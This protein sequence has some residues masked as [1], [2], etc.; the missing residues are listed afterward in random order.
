MPMSIHCSG[1]AAA[2]ADADPV[3]RF[4]MRSRILLKTGE[5]LRMKADTQRGAVRAA[6]LA[7]ALLLTAAAAAGADD[8]TWRDL[9]SRI[10]YGYYTEDTRAL[11]NLRDAIAADESHDKL[12]G[13]YAA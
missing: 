7:A 13:Y 8:S 6:A 1:G 11:H 5:P 10:Q 4:C 3:L 12:H 2:A 9:E